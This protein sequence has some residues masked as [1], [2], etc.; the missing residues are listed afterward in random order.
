MRSCRI[1]NSAR[2]L[3]VV[4]GLAFTVRA[5]DADPSPP[6]REAV[7]LVEKT[8]AQLSDR[9]LSRRAQLALEDEKIKWRHG[10]TEHF[11]F[12]FQRLTEAQR[13]AREAE[14]YYSK[15]KNDLAVESD[16]LEGRSHV[17]MFAKEDRWRRF[18]MEAEVPPWAIAFASGR[19]MFMLVEAGD[20]DASGRLAHEMT[21]LVFF[22]FVPKPVPLWLHEGFAE[23]E[24]K[25][26]YAKFK[27]I[28]QAPPQGQRK[29]AMDLQRLT[30]FKAY[31][32]NPGEVAQFYRESERLVRFLVTQ[33]PRG[34]F[35]PFVNLLADGADFEEALLQTHA[36][37][38]R[39]LDD[40]KKKFDRFQ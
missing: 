6:P 17:I 5:S 30:S 16:R 3:V 26:A 29:A 24:S 37:R 36:A 20:R 14:F 27:G 8:W 39:K 40:F 28:G 22:R 34:T 33:H 7:K 25:A 11:V 31:P 4:A 12:H 38:Y 2:L 10:E 19:E 13:L 32:E 9:S 15:I 1:A 23:Y 18:A 35:V 21:H